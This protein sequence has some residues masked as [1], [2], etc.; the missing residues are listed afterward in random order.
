MVAYGPEDTHFTVELTYNYGISEYEKGNEFIG[1]TI[2]SQEALQR[3]ATEG[4]PIG[5]EE[6]IKFLEAPGGYKFFIIEEP[7]PTESGKAKPSFKIQP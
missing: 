4:W 1:I 5:K 2:K 6:N 7:Q 3:A